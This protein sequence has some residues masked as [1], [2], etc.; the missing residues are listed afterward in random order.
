MDVESPDSDDDDDE[1]DDTN[2]GIDVSGIIGSNRN[3]KERG[4][5]HMDM[6]N[7]AFGLM[8]ALFVPNKTV[9]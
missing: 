1:D 3:R 8:C 7:M 5:Y 9:R 4:E 2:L 6:D